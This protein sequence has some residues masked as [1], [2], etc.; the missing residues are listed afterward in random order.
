MKKEFIFN[1]QHFFKECHA[2]TLVE[3]SGG[4]F[5]ACWFG[6]TKEGNKDVAIWGARRLNGKWTDPVKLAKVN[7]TP[8]WNPVLFKANDV[9]YLFFKV[10]MYIKTWSTWVMSS[11]DN[12]KSWTKPQELV[13]GNRGGR[14]PVKNKPIILSNGIWVAPASVENKW[15]KAFVDLSYDKGKTWVKSKMPQL[16]RNMFANCKHPKGFPEAHGVIQPSLWESS[17]GN[18][19]MLLRSSC[20]YICRS[21][22]S[23]YAH[24]WSK[25]YPT[26]MPNN[27]SG[28]DVAKLNNNV[29]ALICNPVSQNWGRRT[30][31]SL[32]LSDCN[33]TNWTRCLDLETDD[34]EFSYPSIIPT[35][36]G[37]AITYSWNQ[38]RI[39]FVEFESPKWQLEKIYDKQNQIVSC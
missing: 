38:K 34:G 2:S 1:K 36:N 25:I 35:S 12:G 9:I 31:I 5:M 23:D 26:S 3:L 29:L 32:F 17:R 15:W 4:G 30:P 14:G 13:S 28:L 27:N 11:D 37:G 10:G 21:D 39:V 6:G 7:N 22:S 18:V 33:G 16:T 8:H 19:H 20:G 24:S